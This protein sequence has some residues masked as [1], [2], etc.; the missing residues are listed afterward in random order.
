[1]KHEPGW[2]RQWRFGI[3]AAAMLAGLLASPA[4]AVSAAVPDAMSATSPRIISPSNWQYSAG[5]FNTLV[6]AASG[7]PTPTLTM[8]GSLPAGLLFRPN[9]YGAAVISGYQEPGVAGKTFT[10]TITATNGV[11]P[12]A[13]Q[14]LTI[15]AGTTT[16][17]TSVSASPNPAVA[18]QPVTYTAR[19][20]PVPNGGTVYITANGNPIL[21]CSGLPVNTSTGVATCTSTYLLAGS[22]NLAAGYSGYGLFLSSSGPGTYKLVVNPRAPAYWL[23]TTNGRVFGLGAAPS[24]GNANT[25]AGRAIAATAGGQGYYVV[26]AGGGVF[27]FGDARFYGSVP[28]LGKR[29][30][31]IV[32]IAVTSDDKGYYLLGS[33]G[34]IFTF[35]DARFYGSLPGIGVR[36]QH[37]VGM[38]AYPASTGYLLVSRDGG[39]FT[40]GNARFYGSL[41]GM[42]IRT[43]SIRGILPSSAGTGYVLVGADG[44]VFNF[45]TGVR[46]YGSLPGIGVRVSNIVGI[47]LT[48]DEDGYWMAG[49]DGKVYGFGSAKVAAT[50]GGLPANL[51]LAAIASIPPPTPTIGL[52]QRFFNGIVHFLPND[53][54]SGLKVYGPTACGGLDCESSVGFQCPTCGAE[55]Q[56]YPFYGFT[57]IT[58]TSHYAA[59]SYAINRIWI[60]QVL[61]FDL[62]I[63][64]PNFVA[65][66]AV[67]QQAPDRM[68]TAFGLAVGQPVVTVGPV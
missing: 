14:Q 42:N 37:V 19:V 66:S 29:V 2:R 50:P 22:H 25:P 61:G 5:D 18:G 17:T 62:A 44:G 12:S 31:N 11:S 43:T 46:F 24:L 3:V 9:R 13:V 47:A 23:A 57:I 10:V 45:G 1:M 32:A 55:F 49:S 33:D 52:A 56:S 6:V 39:V 59:L 27:A 63:Y 60:A 16:T 36:T 15:I 4:P 64:G 41:P 7:S 30:S 35:G 38:V 67:L 26:G 34:G 58:F 68:V 8:S 28:G 54:F 65:G 40:F 21:G 53:R 48:Q 20:A 51:P